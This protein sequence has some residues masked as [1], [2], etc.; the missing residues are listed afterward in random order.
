MLLKQNKKKEKTKT[1]QINKETEITAETIFP[2]TLILGHR[3]SLIVMR[4]KLSHFSTVLLCLKT[5]CF[6]L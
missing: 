6:K 3:L 5:C 2:I 1:S 4:I